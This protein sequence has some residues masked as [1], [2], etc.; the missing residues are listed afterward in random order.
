MNDANPYRPPST[1]LTG[2]ATLSS[3]EA[4]LTIPCSCGIRVP[5]SFAMAGTEVYCQC[6]NCLVVPNLGE[7]KRLAREQGIEEITQAIGPGAPPGIVQLLAWV[8]ITIGG[9][10][11]LLNML[12]GVALIGNTDSTVRVTMVA[13]LVYLAHPLLP[14]VLG[15]FLLRG[16]KVARYLYIILDIFRLIGFPL[17]TAWGAFGIYVLAFNRNVRRYYGEI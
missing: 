5:V 15:A 2:T 9:I 14:I 12:L 4:S 6:G 17:N 3:S 7:L 16:S 13:L 8:E 11:L 1:S 10:R